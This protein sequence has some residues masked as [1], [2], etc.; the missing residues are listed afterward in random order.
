MPPP[1]TNQNVSQRMMPHFWKWYIP[2]LVIL[3]GYEQRG[4]ACV[5]IVLA[6]IMQAMAPPGTLGGTDITP[7]G[8]EAA[9]SGAA[10]DAAEPAAA[11]AAAVKS[12]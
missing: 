8:E 6:M 2:F 11:A 12:D 7:R 3:V 9:S 4:A 1:R 10:P 5:L